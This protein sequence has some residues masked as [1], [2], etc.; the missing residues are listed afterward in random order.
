MQGPVDDL[1]AWLYCAIEWVRQAVL[2][3]DMV[4]PWTD[5]DGADVPV[6]RRRLLKSE[7][8]PAKVLLQSCP[9]EFFELNAHL[10]LVRPFDQ[11]PNYGY[12]AAVLVRCLWRL[13]RL[14]S[15]DDGFLQK[16]TY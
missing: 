3:Y 7:L 15:D 6:E 8:F 1:W 5:P 4:F 2:G 12:L 9:K 13:A 10:R 14:P 16:M 11:F